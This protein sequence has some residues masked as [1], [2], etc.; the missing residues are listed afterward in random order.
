MSRTLYSLLLRV[1]LPLQVLAFWWRGWRHPVYRGSLRAHL[2]AGLTARADRPLWLHAASA[3]EVQALAGLLQQ[4]RQQHPSLP[5]LL[6]V[7]TPTGL[8]RARELYATWLKP[9]AG[10][11]ALTIQAAPW[12]LPGAARR[13]LRASSPCAGVFAETELWP[14]LVQAAADRR[15]PLLLVS[16]RVSARSTARYLRWAPRLMR[17]TVRA[18]ALVAAQTEADRERFISLGSDPAQVRVDGNLKFDL[19]LAPDV[20]QQGAVLRRRLAPARA[21]WV[22]G[23]THEGEENACLAAQRSLRSIAVAAGKPAPLLVLAP[24]RP[25]RFE[26]VA[27]WLSTQ[28]AGYRR[29]ASIV[30]PG[31]GETAEFRITDDV[32]VLLVDRF[33]DLLV[34]Y[35][36]ADVCFV[37]GTLV[38]VGGHNLLEPAALG[39]PVLAGPHCFN[40][41]ESARLLEAV[42]GLRQVDDESQLTQALR[43]WLGDPAGAAQ[44]GRAAAAAVLANRG[45]AAQALRAITA[46]LVSSTPEA[47]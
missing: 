11:A 25:E 38:P 35:A 45:A 16:A 47:G 28:G 33:G 37:G 43:E 6:T 3:G 13:F 42:G 12:D 40:A 26:A 19:P 32:D 39:K 18:F 41:L 36:A 2:A 17:N 44:A 24:R 30:G 29:Y 8:L 10:V 23:S 22:A 15:L 5:L 7:G 34:C 4:L 14:N 21:M 1:L 27:Q 20:A 31:G 46:L 9:V